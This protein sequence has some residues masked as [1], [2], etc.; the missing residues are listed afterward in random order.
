VAMAAVCRHALEYPWR[1]STFWLLRSCVYAL[2]QPPWQ[3][4]VHSTAA[5][6]LI[7]SLLCIAAALLRPTRQ[8]PHA[9]LW[10]GQYGPHGLEL[11]SVSYDF[12]GSSARITCTKLTGGGRL[13]QLL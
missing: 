13:Q 12:S 2:W 4:H 6:V 8:H 9:G 1:L 3:R 5:A 7:T 10:K 11:S